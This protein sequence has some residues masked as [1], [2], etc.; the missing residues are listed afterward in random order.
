MRAAFITAVAAAFATTTLAA[1]LE[2]RGGYWE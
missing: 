2:K 1:P